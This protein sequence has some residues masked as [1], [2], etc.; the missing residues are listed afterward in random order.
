VKK[1]IAVFLMLLAI[2]RTFLCSSEHTSWS[3]LKEK[4]VIFSGNANYGLAEEVVK[5]LDVPLGD[6]YV[7]RFNDGEIRISVNTNVRN[8]DVF[9]IQSNCPSDIQ[10]VND[11]LMELFLMVRTL[12][13]AS[14]ASITAVIPYYGYARQDRK[15]S[16]RVPISA[17]DV[18]MMLEGAGVDRI[19]TIDLHCG[20]IQGFFQGIPVDNLYASPLFT[21]YFSSKDLHNIVVV[22]PDA[23]GVERA[24]RFMEDLGRRG[25]HAEMALISKQR[26][27]PGVVGSMALIGDVKGATA[28]IIDDLCDTGGTLVKAAKLLK[29]HG[30]HR[31]FAAIT[32]PVFS[33]TALELIRNSEIDD[34]VVTNTIPLRGEAPQNIHNISVAAL[35]GEAIRRIQY[36]ESISELFEVPSSIQLSHRNL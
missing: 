13:R 5:Y 32:H 28:I 8:K 18:A 16:G 27:I 7:G 20:Q 29:E 6:A 15:T 4:A 25:T 36:G 31:V 3:T 35:L 23:G 1:I 24:K 19:V 34:M 10:S 14:A 9:I 11:N 12:K 17:A 22:S 26:E 33:C 2:E 21:S 30:A